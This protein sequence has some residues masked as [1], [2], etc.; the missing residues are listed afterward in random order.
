MRYLYGVL[1]FIFVSNY[2]FAQVNVEKLPN[3][4]GHENKAILNT[5]QSP[6]EVAGKKAGTGID[7]A[8]IIDNST[9]STFPSE[10]KAS[11][12]VASSDTVSKRLRER[13]ISS[14]YRSVEAE[15]LA[16][17]KINE[18][19]ASYYAW[20]FKNRQQVLLQ[21]QKSSSIIF[22]MV[23]ILVLSGLIFSG[24][25]FYIAFTGSKKRVVMPETSFK[26]SLSGVEIS[27]SLLGILI[28]TLSIVFFYLYLI[29]VYPLVSIE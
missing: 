4:F 3:K 19:L 11:Q 2:V 16:N 15:N 26:A 21:Q 1:L 8:M 14:Y 22:Y 12:S 9:R 10:P 7:T 5:I 17:E 24:I 23:L 29:K 25:Q 28:L 27:S 20:A 18:S 13:A 6:M